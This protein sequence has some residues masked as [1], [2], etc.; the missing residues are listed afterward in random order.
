MIRSLSIQG[1]R[2]YAEKRTIEFAIPNGDLGS[3]ITFIVGA[4][5][6]GKTTIFEALRSFNAS[7]DNPPNFSEK[8]RNIKSDNGKVHLSLVT[9]EDEVYQI[10]TNASGGSPTRMTVPTNSYSGGN[11]NLSIYVLQSRRFVEYEFHR[12]I[13]D[14]E[15]YLLND[16]MNHNNRRSELTNFSARLFAMFKNKKKYEP[17]LKRVLG[18][19]LDWTIEQNDNGSFY[20][21]LNVNGCVHSIEGLGDGIWSIFTI[22]DALYDSKDGS[23]I[24]IDEPELSLHPA[25]QKRVMSLLK[26]YAKSRQIIINTHS[27][28]F[29]DT[30]SLINNAYFYRSVKNKDGIIDLF[31]L[32]KESKERLKSFV[33]DLHQ[34]H[35]FGV[36]AKEL[37]FL[38]DGAILVEGQEDVVIFNKLSQDLNI[39]ILGSFWGWGVG[40]ASKMPIFLSILNE[41]GYKKVVAIYDGDKLEDKKNVEKN[42]QEYRFYNISTNDIRDKKEVQVKPAKKGI[43]TEN[44]IIKDEYVTEITELFS[45]VNEYFSGK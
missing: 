35:S 16:Q 38:E 10:D 7:P 14:R 11:I 37:F 34:P 3:G 13:M 36:D 42:Y 31:C 15:N 25:Y 28:Y 6:S 1:L 5:N 32:S 8:K 24:A 33:N 4:N 20:L 45:Q 19:D 23:T 26:E 30:G 9:D 18:Y 43:T 17:L 22:C 2:G 39:N 29:I 40:G 27:P 12:N 21:K 44:G 41:L